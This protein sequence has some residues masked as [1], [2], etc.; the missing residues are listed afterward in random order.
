MSDWLKYEKS[1]QQIV[2][3]VQYQKLMEAADTN[4]LDHSAMLEIA[5]QMNTVGLV[6]GTLR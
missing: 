6:A 3:Q 2:G 4:H 1:V 5:W